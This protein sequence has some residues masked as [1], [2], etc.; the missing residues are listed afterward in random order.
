MEKSKSISQHEK[1]KDPTHIFKA[2]HLNF[3][4]T[5]NASHFETFTLIGC[6]CSNMTA[7]RESNDMNIFTATVMNS[8]D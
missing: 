2:L 6:K 1:E 3:V 8:I 7:Q 5:C 4:R